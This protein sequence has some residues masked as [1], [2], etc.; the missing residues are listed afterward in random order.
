MSSEARRVTGGQQ[1][2]SEPVATVHKKKDKEPTT[3]ANQEAL[4]ET[5]TGQL[6]FF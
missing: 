1:K 4:K 6:M 2:P 5:K 3:K